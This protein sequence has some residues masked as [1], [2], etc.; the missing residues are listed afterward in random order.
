MRLDFRIDRHDV[1][2]L[3]HYAWEHSFAKVESNRKAIAGR[4]WNPLTLNL[5]DQEELHREKDDKAIKNTYQLAF[6]HGKENVDPSCLNFDSGVTKTLMDKIIEQKIRDRALDQAC[7]EQREDHH[8]QSLETF[9]RCLK[10][11]AGAAF[12][13]GTVDVSA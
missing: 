13:A 1:I 2:G 8:A 4:G 12:N 10:M 5:L 6:I 11:T 9:N 7:N 3:V